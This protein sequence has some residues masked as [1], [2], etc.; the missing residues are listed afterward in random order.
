MLSPVDRQKRAAA[1]AAM[2]WIQDDQVIGLGT[3]STVYFF[4][5]LLAQR[6]KSG[7]RI[8]G[9][10]TSRHTALL[11]MEL[12]IPLLH[13][14][15]DWRVDVAVDGADLVDDRMNLVKGG[16]GA[17]VREKIVAWAAREF[18]VIVD[19]SK[20]APALGAPVPIPVE[21]LPFGWPS[22]VR[23]LRQFAP[24]PT[25]RRINGRP[26]VT[27]N[28]HY[29]VDLSIERIPDPLSLARELNTVPGVVENGLFIGRTT[30][31]LTGTTQGVD[32]VR[33]PK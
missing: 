16:G 18:I 3:G 30:V 9:V 19:E 29:I 2:A 27:D 32:L 22:T 20:R 8:H 33:S 13:E 25:L 23:H 10:P 6:V 31:L 28:G 7:L 5:E 4:L 12:G 14:E 24:S 15:T 17:L 21:V 1:E 11:A 26:F